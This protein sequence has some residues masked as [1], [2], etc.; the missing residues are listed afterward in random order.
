MQGINQ[1]RHAIIAL[2]IGISLKL[3]GNLVLIRYFESVG[4]VLSTGIG[5]FWSPFGIQIYRFVSMQTL[6]FTLVYKRIFQIAI[7]SGVMTIVVKLVQWGL[8]PLFGNSKSQLA[9]AV[10]VAAG[11]NHWCSCLR[12]PGDSDGHAAAYIWGRAFWID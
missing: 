9:A 5:F 1:Q 3:I 11:G 2:A 8:S 7:L 10:V 12:F 6:I 4:A